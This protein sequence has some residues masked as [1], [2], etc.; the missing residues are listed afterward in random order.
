MFTENFILDVL[1]CLT[2]LISLMSKD[3]VTHKVAFKLT[4]CRE[5]LV[6]IIFL[7]TLTNRRDQTQETESMDT[8]AQVTAS[9]ETPMDTDEPSS[10][11]PVSQERL[12]A[13]KSAVHDIFR[14]TRES[15][16]PV[17][18]VSFT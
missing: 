10:S 11:T 15:N 8:T 12:A 2:F 1:N 9:G 3:S 17:T 14:E 7:F 4:S 13:F 18:D 6:D 16:L 5:L